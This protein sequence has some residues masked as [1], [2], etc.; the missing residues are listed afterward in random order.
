MSSTDSLFNS[1][2]VDFYVNKVDLYDMRSI[3]NYDAVSDKINK[4]PEIL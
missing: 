3:Q 1:E 2:I 4:Y